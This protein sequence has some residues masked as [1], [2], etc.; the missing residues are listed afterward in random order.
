ML[1]VSLEKLGGIRVRLHPLECG[2]R[3]GE[4]GLGEKVAPLEQGLEHLQR[5]DLHLDR[6]LSLVEQGQHV[7]GQLG[8]Y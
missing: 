1:Q 7:L 2:E 8:S 6:Q 4:L 5:V 3:L